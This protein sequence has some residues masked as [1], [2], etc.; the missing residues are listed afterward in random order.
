MFFASVLGK[1]LAKG[2][3]P[4][5]ARSKFYT[6]D[7]SFEWAPCEVINYH[8]PTDTYTIKWLSNGKPKNVKRYRPPSPSKP[9][10]GVP[11]VTFV[12]QNLEVGN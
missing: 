8:Q 9:E 10:V 7:G 5:T 4:P 2:E 11:L 6:N 1:A 3:L 12:F